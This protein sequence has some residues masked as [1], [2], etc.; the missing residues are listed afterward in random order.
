MEGI[1]FSGI[2]RVFEQARALE[3]QGKKII[4]LEIG[5]PDFDTPAHIKDAAIA[6][7]QEGKVH[8]T[9]NWGIL[10]LREAVS[11]S[12]EKELGL[13]YDPEGE[14]IIT[15]GAAEGVLNTIM[16]LVDPGDEVLVPDPGWVNYPAATVMAH[17]RS[18]PYSLRAENDFQIDLEEF[19][20]LLSPKTKLV[21]LV[22]PH[23][24]TGGM[25]E[26]HILEEISDLANKQGFFIMTDEIYNKMTYDGH[27]HVS[28]AGLPGMKDRTIIIN[29][30]SKAYSMTGW[31][32][33]YVAAPKPLAVTINKVHQHNTTCAASFAQYGALAALTGTQDCVL[34]MVREF[35]RR[36][37]FLWEGIN[38]IP[39]LSCPKPRG[40]FYAFVDVRG[41]GLSAEEFASRL[42]S[43][44]GVAV[45]PGDVF[46]E[47]GAGFIRISYASS[48][49][50]IQE[51]L[52]RI[53]LFAQSLG[54]TT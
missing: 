5:R 54:G 28:I 18:V 17:G 14:I 44:A 53:K 11:K 9:S 7:L 35:D 40:A 42:L 24:P 16:A 6:A 10:P 37:L 46:G 41:C 26:K 21:V 29:G 52:E 49:Q 1:P 12:L 4:H 47:A 3:A 32:V 34:D 2:R 51:A 13:I 19:K 33:G 31:R 43:E 25:L 30:F 15:S 48:Y 50:E 36:R 39:G 38:A 22:T 27:R 8:Y 20:N 23:N 45:V